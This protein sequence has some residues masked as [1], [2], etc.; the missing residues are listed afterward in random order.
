MFAID[1]EWAVA[2][3]YL[4][5]PAENEPGFAICPA[6]DAVI[7]RYRPL[8]QYPAL[9]AEFAKLDGSK[10]RC[11]GFAHKY[12]LLHTDLTRRVD[13]GNNPGVLETLR[14][15]K[16]QIK[17]IKGFIQRCELSRAQP[18]QAFRRFANRDTLL[19]GV[20]LYLANKSPNSQASVDVRVSSLFAAIE[21][22]TITSIIQGRVSVQCIECSGWF[23]IGAGARRS[24]SKFCSTRCKDNYH[25]RLKA[26]KGTSGVVGTSS[27]RNRSR[28]E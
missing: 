3:K 12:G 24:Q 11:L 20:D 16:G 22:Q 18:T 6:D 4:L 28:E 25:N 27:V 21:L 9:Y 2:S 15:W 7:T 14:H 13:L 1:L 19:F 26:L 8:D 23:E 5:R 10:Q 17:I